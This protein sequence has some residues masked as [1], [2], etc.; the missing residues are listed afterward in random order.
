MMAEYNIYDLKAL[1]V[2][3]DR[4]HRFTITVYT[5]VWHSSKLCEVKGILDSL[6][7]F[8]STVF[9]PE[10]FHSFC[11]YKEAVKAEKKKTELD[12]LLKTVKEC[13]CA[14]IDALADIERQTRDGRLVPNPMQSGEWIKPS[15]LTELEDCK[16]IESVLERMEAAAGIL[17]LELNEEFDIENYRCNP[18]KITEKGLVDC[19]GYGRHV[20]W[21]SLLTGTKTIIKRP[22]APWEP[23]EGGEYW[24][25]SAYD[26]SVVYDDRFSYTCPLGILN[27]RI[28][29]C[30]PDR[31]TAL[32]N[33]D[34]MLE[35][36]SMP[37]IAPEDSASKAEAVGDRLNL[38]E[39]L[40]MAKYSA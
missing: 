38:R 14:E 17:G 32:A 23:K 11:E 4:V 30:F 15:Q 25:V 7:H 31:K 6:M 16:M 27:Y 20:L 24:F 1:G 5:K 39:R 36:F 26:C 37:K 28:G 10:H 33:V 8:N 13:I 12:R 35:K 21:Q 40:G 34:I 9:D 19:N 3:M 2:A 22:K 29:N 18:H